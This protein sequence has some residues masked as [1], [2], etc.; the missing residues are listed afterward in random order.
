MTIRYV[1]PGGS[2]GNSGLTWALRKETLNGVE[3][4]PVVAGDV[5]YVGPGTYREALTC[6]VTGSS[7]N[8]IEYIA[9]VTGLNTD[10]L[11]GLVRITA[12]DSD[13]GYAARTNLLTAGSGISHRA[14]TGLHF[15]I[16]GGA[17]SRLSIVK[18]EG[19]L[20]DSCTFGATHKNNTGAPDYTIKI[21]GTA[22]TGGIIRNCMFLPSSGQI[23][24]GFDSSQYDAGAVIENCIFYRQATG[25][26]VI[27]VYNITVRNC[28][29]VSCEQAIRFVAASG[30][31]NM[32]VY[33]SMFLNNYD[34]IVVTNYT[35]IDN[36]NV[37]EDAG[38]SGANNI[39]KRAYMDIPILLKGVKFPWYDYP[40]RLRGLTAVTQNGDVGAPSTDL[41]G[42]TRP[43]SGKKTPGAIQYRE[44]LRQT[45]TI[46]SGTTSIELVDAARHVFS[47]IAGGARRHRFVVYVYREANYAGTLPQ[48]VIK[49]LGQ[50]DI[51][52]TDTGSS[53]QW[54]KLSYDL[55]PSASD[56]F[57]QVELVSNN[58]AT[59][60]S[61]KTFFDDFD[62]KV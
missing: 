42:L 40:F 26:D 7:G 45:T 3:D 9:D 19:W 32:Y 35:L 41:F 49:R 2:N 44:I 5:I 48:M 60:G 11:G 1:G 14:F 56:R 6:D 16:F 28:T 38:F 29:F 15:G 21:T 33:N 50:S 55:T 51:T 10:G 17:G 52:V 4:T 18:F 61:Y 8:L 54:N 47:L 46:R 12:L 20:I 25:V 59:S 27:D 36:Y 13:S 62:M 57:I 31:N 53:G 39:A 43:G 34:D 37:T 58:T 22:S 24:V 23:G 30:S